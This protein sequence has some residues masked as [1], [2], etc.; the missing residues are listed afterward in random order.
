MPLVFILTINYFFA[1]KNRA[2]VMVVSS[3][4]L[5]FAKNMRDIPH[6]KAVLIGDLPLTLYTIHKN[7]AR[8]LSVYNFRADFTHS[9]HLSSV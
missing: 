4:E 7:G 5:T 1:Q 2:W 3:K 9:S 6:N 8:A